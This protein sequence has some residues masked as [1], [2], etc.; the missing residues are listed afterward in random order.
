LAI[1]IDPEVKRGHGPDHMKVLFLVTSCRPRR[2]PFPEVAL[3]S[4]PDDLLPL[5]PE[6]AAEAS[7]RR[8]PSI[9]SYFGANLKSARLKVDLPRQSWSRALGLPQQYVSLIESGTQN[10]TLITAQTSCAKICP[11]CCANRHRDPAKSNH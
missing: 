1:S 5:Q 9:V 3:L 10:V 11:T 7:S 6:S 4:F 8:Q 2:R